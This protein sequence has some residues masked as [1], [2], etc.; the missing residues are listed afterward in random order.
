MDLMTNS[1]EEK[2]KAALQ[3][4]LQQINPNAPLKFTT[5]LQVELDWILNAN[6]SNVERVQV[7]DNILSHNGIVLNGVSSSLSNDNDGLL[8]SSLAYFSII[9]DDDDTNDDVTTKP[10]N[11]RQI[12]RTIPAKTISNFPN[13]HQHTASITT[14]A[15]SKIGSVDLHTMDQWLA[16]ILWPNQDQEDRML[17]ALVGQMARFATGPKRTRQFLEGCR[18]TVC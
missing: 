14:I 11:H 2:Q 17:P 7:I 18:F 1:S 4:R 15:L 12:P 6:C 16:T 3:D 13:K 5:Y 8:L 9:I 10:T